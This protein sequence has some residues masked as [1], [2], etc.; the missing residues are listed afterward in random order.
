VR[1]A[2]GG[3]VDTDSAVRHRHASSRARSTAAS[4]IRIV[5]LIAHASI[6]CSRAETA[7]R[8]YRFSEKTSRKKTGILSRAVYT[9]SR[10]PVNH[11]EE[12]QMA[13]RKKA[14]SKKSAT[15]KKVAKKKVAAKKKVTA[16]KSAAKKKT[17][18]KKAAKKRAAK[19]GGKKK[20]AKKKVAKKGGKKKAAKKK[21]AKKRTA[22]KK[23]AAM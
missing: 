3:A 10:T 23:T 18:K 16:K 6:A 1:A 8:L 7:R 12:T 11:L 17:A 21:A 22:K 13:T 2:R 5:G 9:Q 19:K 20:A 4:G 14:A 15:K